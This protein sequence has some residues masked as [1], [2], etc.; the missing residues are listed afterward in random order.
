MEIRFV[1]IAAFRTA[2][3]NLLKVKKGVYASVP[4]EI[5]KAFQNISIE[6]IRQNRDMILMDNDS[7]TIKLRLPD[8]KQR[9]SKADGYRLIYMVMKNLLVVGLLTVYPKRGP[10][11]K[12]DLEDGEL[13]MLMNAFSL[14]SQTQQV[15]VHDINNN[16]KVIPKSE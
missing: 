3:D 11:Q 10:M 14:E 1:S 5:C 16:L 2:L 15:V 13:E 6:Q 7:I 9:L 4:Q 8:K 12:L